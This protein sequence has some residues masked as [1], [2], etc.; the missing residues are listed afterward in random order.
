MGGIG[1][2]GN[3]TLH[4][5]WTRSSYGDYPS[6]YAGYQ[7]PSDA[8]NSVSSVA[9]HPGELLKAGTDQYTGERWGDYVGVAQDPIV[10]SAV[11]QA[12]EYSGTGLHGS[13]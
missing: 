12:N 10:P 2:A 4:V 6:S 9:S 5:V 13:A 8:L 7:L 3:G 11:W 1:M